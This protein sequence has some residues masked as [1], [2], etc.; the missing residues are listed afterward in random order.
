MAIFPY[1]NL[2]AGLSEIPVTIIDHRPNSAEGWLSICVRQPQAS[3]I[4]SPQPLCP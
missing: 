2:G 1:G 4:L 3:E